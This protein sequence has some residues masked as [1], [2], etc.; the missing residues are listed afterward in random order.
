M[1]VFFI[2]SISFFSLY[3]YSTV[4]EAVVAV[5]RDQAIYKS[6]IDSYRK[7]LTL[8]SWKRL[9]LMNKEK[10][11]K[12]LINKKTA[13][14]HLIN[15][16][17]IDSVASKAGLTVSEKNV[18]DK[19]K[20]LARSKNMTVQQFKNSLS[21]KRISLK[22][23][24][25]TLLLDIKRNQIIQRDV[26]S[27]INVPK[28]QILNRLKN[29]NIFTYE[30]SID[31][32]AYTKRA[33]AQKSI[34]LLKKTPSLFSKFRKKQGGTLGTFKITELRSELKNQ[35]SKLSSGEINSTLVF[36]NSKYYIL[37]VTKKKKVI[38]SKY[39]KTFLKEERK[40][41]K[42]KLEQVLTQ[43]TKNL[44]KNSFVKINKS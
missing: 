31:Y 6:D 19:I 2:L 34:S 16:R 37:K 24:K 41:Y 5:V 17:L 21:K 32:L 1:K 20:A 29:K 30:F 44:R 27:K 38:L 35:I 25:K 14:D 11:K 10:Y 15:L 23:F 13:L 39:K 4:I 28:E 8:T 7:K 3:S 36:M 40:I 33:S 22:D 26:N 18:R 12:I 42:K 43:W 9:P